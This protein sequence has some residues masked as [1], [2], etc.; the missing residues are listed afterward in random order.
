M[1]VIIVKL[2]KYYL[3][4]LIPHSLSTPSLSATTLFIRCG[5]QYWF[6]SYSRCYCPW[7]CPPVTCP[8]TPV[9][10]V[11]HPC[12]C[13]RIDWAEPLSAL[14]WTPAR[15]PASQWGSVPSSTRWPF[16]PQD[17]SPTGTRRPCSPWPAPNDC[18]QLWVGMTQEE[19]KWLAGEW[20]RDAILASYSLCISAPAVIAFRILGLSSFPCSGTVLGWSGVSSLPC[21]SCC[22]PL[23]VRDFLSSLATQMRHTQRRRATVV[24]LTFCWGSVPKNLQVRMECGWNYVTYDWK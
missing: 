17:P 3:L 18:L 11:S 2:L 5:L 4:L 23:P 6:R 8:A 1:K 7:H 15:P 16:A 22:N 20:D 24:L 13:P 14:D 19:I 12:S 21:W 10:S 9:P